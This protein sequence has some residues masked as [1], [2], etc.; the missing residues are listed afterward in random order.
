MKLIKKNYA[1]VNYVLD[2]LERNYPGPITNDKL[3]KNPDKYL[4]VNDP[5]DSTNFSLRT[6]TQEGKDYK[7]IPKK[8]WEI[9]SSQFPNSLEIRR[10]KDSDSYLR[11]Y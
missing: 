9:L 3:L 5:K 4:R 11:K 10:F 1:H 7:L 6:K 8:C 2:D